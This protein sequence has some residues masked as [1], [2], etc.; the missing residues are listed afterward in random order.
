LCLPVVG[1]I[2]D[3]RDAVQAILNGDPVGA[4]MNAAG[5]IPGPGDGIKIT[6]ARGNSGIA[7][8]QSELLSMVERRWV[9]LRPDRSVQ[10]DRCRI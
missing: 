3:I 1:G 8:V 9:V 7:P 5:A 6:G 10:E 4:A 2:A